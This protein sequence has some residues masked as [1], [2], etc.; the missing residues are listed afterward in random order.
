[1]CTYF[2]QCFELLCKKLIKLSLKPLRSYLEPGCFFI[3]SNIDAIFNSIQAQLFCIIQN[4]HKKC[5][6]LI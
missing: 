2:K 3:L 5:D 1:M 6:H 4:I